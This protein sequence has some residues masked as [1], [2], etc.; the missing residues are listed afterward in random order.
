LFLFHALV[1]R[2]GIGGGFQLLIRQ[3]YSVGVLSLA[4]VVV[5]GVF[6]G[7]VL[8]LQ[9]YSILTK[10]GSEQAVGPMVALTPLRELGPVVTALLF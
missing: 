5:S 2:G 1:G 8:A 7:M 6:I 3:L 4:I 9:G 10:Y